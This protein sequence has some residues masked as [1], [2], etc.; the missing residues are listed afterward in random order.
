MLR[1][2]RLSALPMALAL[3][4]AACSTPS[5]EQSPASTGR[6]ATP[7]GSEAE[8][9]SSTS[10]AAPAW[11]E[12]AD[13]PLARLEMATAAHDGRIWLAGGLSPLG[14]AVSEV[15]VYDPVSEAWTSGP[16]LP[17]GI[18]HA[19]LVS[20]GERLLLIGGYI[21]TSFNQPTGIVLVLADGADTWEAGPSLPDPRAAGGAAWDGARVV[22]AGGVGIGGVSGD[23]FA[24]AADAW[25][26]IGA[27][28]QAREHLAATSDG[29]GRT[30][31]MGGRVGSL[32]SNLAD[33]DLVEGAA[34]TA[35]EPLPTPRGGV[36]A[37]FVPALGACLTGGEAPAEAYRTVECIGPDGAVVTGPQ[38]AVQRHGHG[39][40]VVDGIAYVL[41]GGSVPGLSAHSSVERLDPAP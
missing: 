3:A 8:P 17:T 9:G 1:A 18:H 20:D 10:P 40:A 12:V 21:G 19:A 31:L 24:L 14:E 16:P 36:A 26:R 23:V 27:M 33:V 38:M 6:P 7:V 28:P 29:E 32:E 35:L 2:A 15:E 30:W 22:Y 5:P 37:F 4:L 11:A 41:I 25:E 39:A 13:A 34:V